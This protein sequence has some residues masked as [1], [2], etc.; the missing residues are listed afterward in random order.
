M[1]NNSQKSEGRRSRVFSFQAEPDVELALSK[2]EKLSR[3]EKTRRINEAIR[4]H[5]SASLREILER[6]IEEKKRL[7]KSLGE[8]KR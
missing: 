4:L 7:L 2:L 8:D 3:G 6:D 5:L 1:K